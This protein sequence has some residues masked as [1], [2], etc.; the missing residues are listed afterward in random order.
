MI[1]G[2]GK[3][4]FRLFDVRSL[5]AKRSVVKSIIHRLKNRFNI[6]IAETDLNNRH[7]W[8]QVG[9]AVVGNDARMV[10]SKIDKVMN[11]AD[12]MGLAMIADSDIEII[13]L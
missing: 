1:V 6:S 8:A 4:T 3:I 2:T 5:K 10:N 13:H 12:E 9:F 7:E 11:T